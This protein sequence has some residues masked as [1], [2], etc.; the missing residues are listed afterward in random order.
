MTKEEKE[1]EIINYYDKIPKAMLNTPDNPN[2]KKHKINTPFKMVIQAYSGGGKTNF[3][4]NLLHLFSSGKGTFASIHI[5]TANKD[6]PLY[7]W[8]A[9]KSDQIVISEGVEKTPNIDDFDKNGNHLIVFDDLVLTKD[10]RVIENIY[11]R[12]RKQNCSVIYISQNYYKIPPTIRRNL[13]YLV[14]LK[15]S[16][17]RD[18]KT[19][20]S[21]SSLGVSKEQLLG[22]YQYATKQKFSP[23]VIDMVADPENRFRKGLLEII[24]PDDF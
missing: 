8:L 15:L 2:F 12:G 9:K 16:G 14:L 23:L 1:G 21:E 11:I 17:N 3:L 4:L 10:Q 13:D 6:E 20:L 18:I 24:D 7:N 5:I 22:M 19:I